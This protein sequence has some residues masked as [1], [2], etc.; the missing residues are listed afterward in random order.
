M[1]ASPS[2]CSC[3][4]LVSVFACAAVAEHCRL[5]E[6]QYTLK[7]LHEQQQAQP[8]RAQQQQ[9]QP[10]PPAHQQV[11]GEST[12]EDSEEGMS[13]QEQ[14]QE[15]L[16]R[17]LSVRVVLQRLPAVAPPDQQPDDQQESCCDSSWQQRGLQGYGQMQQ[18]AYTCVLEYPAFTL[19]VSASATVSLWPALRQIQASHHASES[20]LLDIG[21]LLQEQDFCLCAPE[22]TDCCLYLVAE[23]GL[24]RGVF[25][26]HQWTQQLAGAAQ[27]RGLHHAL[28]R[29]GLEV[30]CSLLSTMLLETAALWSS[31]LRRA[32]ACSTVALQ[33]CGPSVLAPVCCQ[34]VLTRCPYMR[35]G[36]LCLAID[37]G[38][39]GTLSGAPRGCQSQWSGRGTAQTAS[40]LHAM[41]CRQ[42]LN[43]PGTDAYGR[44]AAHM[45]SCAWHPAQPDVP[46][47]YAAAVVQLTASASCH[48]AIAVCVPRAGKTRMTG[49]L[50][51]LGR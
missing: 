10:T 21:V 38:G 24:H 16:C 22:Q 27:G 18:L 25:C 42:A 45:L 39:L 50:G 23:L 41:R 26:V 20:S 48:G 29:H 8:S 15:P 14:Q 32:Y 35:A 13:A 19:R 37:S 31:R 17:R 9:Q 43:V 5:L 6:V 1:H 34:S 11:W 46:A 47:T 49:C 12:D 2:T 33:V 30:R 36:A 3:C 4:R 40:E 28:G 51:T 44:E 7:E